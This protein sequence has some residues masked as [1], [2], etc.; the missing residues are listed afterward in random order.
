[1]PKGIYDRSKSAWVPPPRANDPPELVERI[2]TL[3]ESGLTIRQTADEIGVTVK[4][5]QRIMPRYGIT[6]RV[7]KNL[8]QDGPKNPAW[9]GDAAK[10]AALHLRV[11]TVRGKPKECARCGENNPKRRYE[12]ANLTGDYADVYDYIRMCVSCHRRFDAAR[13]RAN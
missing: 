8:N 4:V 3:Y 13:R 9:K 12:W 5:L 7:A 2:R 6:R 10:Y 11:G 1:M